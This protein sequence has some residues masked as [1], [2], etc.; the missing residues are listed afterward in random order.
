MKKFLSLALVCLLLFSMTACSAKED[1]SQIRDAGAK[2]LDALLADDFEGSYAM[3]QQVCSL[4]EY[5]AV[6][7]QF[8]SILSGIRTYE[9]QL[10]QLQQTASNGHTVTQAV[11]RIRWEGQPVLMAVA[12]DSDVIGLRSFQLTP[13]SDSVVSY[14]GDLSNMRDATPLQWCLLVVA[15]A[16][17]AFVLWMAVDCCRR[18]PKRWGLWLVLIL[19]GCLLLTATFQKTAFNFRFHIGMFLSHSALL[20]Y[21]DGSMQLRLLIPL[22][23]IVYCVQRKKL[24]P[25]KEIPADEAFPSPQQ[26]EDPSLPPE[27][28]Q[29]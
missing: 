18:K 3:V 22:V 9:L 19:L 23:A 17:T 25:G 5:T 2:M 8:R 26:P 27:Q 24:T 11:Y 7:G 12:I 29:P 1:E 20:R 13:E 10:L 14:N 21:S 4:E 28:E 6:Y 16:T 15:L